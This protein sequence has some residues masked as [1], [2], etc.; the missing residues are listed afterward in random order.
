MKVYLASLVHTARLL[1]K[2]GTPNEILRAAY[3]PRI[4]MPLLE[5]YVYLIKDGEYRKK[6]D[7][8]NR[9]IFIDSGAF[10]AFTKKIV[11]DLKEYARWLQEHDRFVE[12]AASLDEIG[13]GK[14]KQSYANWRTLTKYGAKTIP[15]HHARDHDDWLAR[16]LDEGVEH[17]A[18]GGMVP[19]ST[20]YLRGWLDRIWSKYLTNPDGTA[21]IKVHGFGMTTLGLMVRYPWYSVDSTS[22]VLLSRYGGVMLDLPGGDVKVAFSSKSPDIQKGHKGTHF[23]SLSKVEQE[24]VRERLEEMNRDSGPWLEDDLAKE[25]EDMTG[26]LRQGFYPETLAEMYGWRDLANILFFDR[27]QRRGVKHFT[28]RSGYLDL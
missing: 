2:A 26:G 15:T 3:F 20:E 7:L 11:I 18:L 25:L 16:Y 21:K 9:G 24:Q 6:L 14:E 5:S 1:G 17:M 10:T 22:W 8:I 4:H 12:V 13:A 27:L 23:L 19:E 28:V